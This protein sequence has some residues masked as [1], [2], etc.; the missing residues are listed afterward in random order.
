MENQRGRSLV[1][2]KILEIIECVF[3][4]ATN[5]T[6]SGGGPN[7]LLIRITAIIRRTLIFFIAC[8]RDSDTFVAIAH[9]RRSP[10]FGGWSAR[11]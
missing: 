9:A 2:H 10:S 7:H 5:V 3:G 11:K 1:A 6:V 4:C 8:I